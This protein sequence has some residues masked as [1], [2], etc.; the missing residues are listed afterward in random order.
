LGCGI[1]IFTIIELFPCFTH[2]IGA[3]PI[4]KENKMQASGIRCFI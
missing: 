2:S 3:A 4:E 1:S